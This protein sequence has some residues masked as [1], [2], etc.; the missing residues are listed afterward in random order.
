MFSGSSS[1]SSVSGGLVG[2]VSVAS[3]L[4]PAAGSSDGLLLEKRK[5]KQIE[6]VWSQFI[7]IKSSFFEFFS[8][9]NTILCVFKGIT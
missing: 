8:R 6:R 3:S 2:D 5:K 4:D 7:L 1:S 9:I